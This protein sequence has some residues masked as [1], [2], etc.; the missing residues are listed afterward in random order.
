VL[1]VAIAVTDDFEEFEW[2]DG[3]PFPLPD[4][5]ETEGDV[6]CSQPT[7]VRREGSGYLLERR[8]EIIDSAGSRQIAIDRITLDIVTVEGVEEA[9]HRAGLTPLG[10]RSIPPT[11]EHIGSEVV[12]FG[13]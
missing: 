11:I 9:G 3:D 6:Y 7:A 2:H 12:L 8:R 1:A 10:L 13:G 4:I 5:L